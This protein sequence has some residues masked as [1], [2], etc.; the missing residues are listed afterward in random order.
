MRS[1]DSLQGCWNVRPGRR[2]N[3]R[4]SKT[5]NRAL[6]T[7]GT[8]ALRSGRSA[9]KRCCVSCCSLKCH[10]PVVFT[11]SSTAKTSIS[12]LDNSKI[13]L[14]FT[15]LSQQGTRHACVDLQQSQPGKVAKKA[16]VEVCW[17]LACLTLGFWWSTFGAAVKSAPSLWL[18]VPPNSGLSQ[19]IAEEYQGYS[20]VNTFHLPCSSCNGTAMAD[21]TQLWLVASTVALW[22]V[23]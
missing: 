10:D 16:A 19:Q 17:R 8:G 3:L 12:P 14:Q 18:P 2:D 5:L 9:V 4:Q 1:A 23:A 20:P 22:R 7:Q 11:Q 21:C 6:L 13:D 15:E